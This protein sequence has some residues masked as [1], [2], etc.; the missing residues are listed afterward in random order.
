MNVT[1][2]SGKAGKYS[3]LGFVFGSST[4]TIF[5]QDSVTLT[6]KFLA[7]FNP[8]L[9]PRHPRVKSFRVKTF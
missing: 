8:V 1:A 2:V 7:Y 4:V 3:V 6:T 9:H 5:S